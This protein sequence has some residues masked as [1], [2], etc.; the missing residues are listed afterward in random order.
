MQPL[1]S[2]RFVVVGDLMLDRYLY[3]RAERIS[4]EAPVP[5]LLLEREE[6]RLGGAA[7]VALNLRALG[8]QVEMAGVVGSDA[9]GG[10]LREEAHRQ[11]IGLFALVEDTRRPTTTKTRLIA[12]HQHMLRVDREVTTPLSPPQENALLQKVRFLLSQ[13]P[14]ALILEDYNKGVLTLSVIRSLIEAARAENI[15]VLVDP[16]RDNFWAYEGVTVFKPNLRELSEALGRK[17]SADLSS[18]HEAIQELRTRMPHQYTVVTLSEEGVVVAD[19][20][21]MFKHVPAHK[22]QIVDVSGA[23]DT[24]VS[25][26]AIGVAWGLPITQAAALANLAGGL[27]CEYVGVVPVPR[28]LWIAQAK[29]LG[30]WPEDAQPRP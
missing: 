21:G 22:R 28:D 13:K 16:K 17:V 6:S 30:L 11:G 10:I 14:H 1:E 5:I 26:L 7:N 23:G 3:G 25:V 12:H 15:P 18:L 4:P 29:H 27:V 8:C 24:V 20:K 19:D 9:A 2:L